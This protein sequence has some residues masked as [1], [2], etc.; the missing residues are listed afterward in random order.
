M[1]A[2]GNFDAIKSPL[3]IE[4]L[5]K[6]SE[7]FKTLSNPRD[8]QSGPQTHRDRVTCRYSSWERVHNQSLHDSLTRIL[9]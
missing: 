8:I 2:Q 7:G 3:I 9:D 4:P 6:V 1:S 5:S